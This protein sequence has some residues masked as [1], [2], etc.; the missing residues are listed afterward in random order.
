MKKIQI[1]LAALLVMTACTGCG[2]AEKADMP[3]E[4]ISGASGAK[5]ADDSSAAPAAV[6]E[7]A[8]AD[9]EAGAEEAFDD[10]A[11]EMDGAADFAAE[12][13]AKS[14]ADV[15]AEDGEADDYDLTQ[16]G[17]Q[18]E[19]GLLTAGEWRDHDNWGFFANLVNSNVIAF[20]SFGIDPTQRIAV[21]IVNNAGEALPNATVQLL[22]ADGGVIWNAVTDKSGMA[23]LFETN[24]R[25]GVSVSAV[26][27]D[28][29]AA[30]QTL[31][32]AGGTDTQSVQL[33]TDRQTTL[34]ID[35]APVYYPEMQVLFIVDTTGSM[36]DEML[37][38]QSDFSAIAEEIG[39]DNT[40][41]AVNFYRDEGDAYVVKAGSFTKDVNAICTTL[42]NE[43]ADGGGDEPEAVAEAL[44][45]SFNMSDW[46]DESVKVAFLIFDAPPHT[47]SDTMLTGA[48]EAAAAK[49]IHVVP[50][51]S[52]NG[53]RE[54]E[55]FGRAAA[56][57]T[58]GTY[59]FLTDDSGIGDSHLEPIIGD[60]EVEKLH[61]IIVRILQDYQQT[62]ATS[63]IVD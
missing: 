8:A 27:A 21:N 40:S 25:T 54:T 1:L 52:S 23:Y 44:S 33:V 28:G 2:N 59:V 37:Y 53:S 57:C 4:Y 7:N 55:L 11:G 14:E 63:V 29:T 45:E 48:I 62:I 47:G 6:M 50:V 24:G 22:D 26:N 49:G 15:M 42:N 12:A 18:A 32:D 38:L 36:G 34:T 43:N 9:G 39:S 41:Y 61:D 60:Y 16:N 30:Q 58:N 20:P 5:S 3:L 35:A 31:E 13:A 51:V 56:I 17:M 10:A 19:A 46:H